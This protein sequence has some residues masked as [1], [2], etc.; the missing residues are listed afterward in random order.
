MADGRFELTADLLRQRCE[1]SQ[2]WSTQEVA[3]NDAVLQQ[4]KQPIACSA[5]NSTV[6]MAELW[7]MQA[8]KVVGWKIGSDPWKKPLA[9]QRA[10]QS[11]SVN[12][13][14]SKA[15]SNIDARQY[16]TAL[17]ILR[18][19]V[20]DDTQNAEAFYLLGFA[21]LKLKNYSN[22]EGF[23]ARALKINANHLVSDSKLY[24]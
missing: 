17:R 15:R 3:A 14:I 12:A 20:E 5:A 16:L 10:S 22:A 9:R 2:R 8:L 4:R 7:T 19:V 23:F 13:Q 24:A 6:A 1:R 11:S 21:S 18:S